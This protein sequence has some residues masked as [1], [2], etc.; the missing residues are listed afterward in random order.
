MITLT[1]EAEQEAALRRMANE[2][3][4]SVNELA[5]DAIERLLEDLHDAALADERIT[6]PGKTW[7]AKEAKRE[8]GL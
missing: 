7:T 8:L 4:R 2:E 5:K 6:R 3:G 1:L